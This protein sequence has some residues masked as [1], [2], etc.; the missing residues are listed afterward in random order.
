MTQDEENILQ[1]TEACSFR[2]GLKNPGFSYCHTENFLVGFFKRSAENF[3]HPCKHFHSAYEF[4]IPLSPITNL[5]A[6]NSVYL[7]EPNYIYP[8][9]SGRKHGIKYSQNNVSFISIIIEKVFF[10]NMM[11]E[12]GSS[13]MQF[14]TRLVYSDAL[15]DYI[16]NFRNEFA[17][18][19]VQD[20]LI[21]MPLRNLICA[22]LIRC[23]LTD[24]PDSRK[25]SSGYAPGISLVVKF[26]NDNYD[27]EINVEELAKI[28]G[29][30]KTYFSSMF[31]NIFGT[32]PK[33]YVNTLR[34]AKAK[35]LLE[36]SDTP[37]KIIATSCGFN[38][39]NTFFCAFRKS[40]NMTPSEFKRSR[41]DSAI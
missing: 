1:L 30:S 38:S 13:K 12:F 17:H 34:I 22:E 14:N 29:L 6:E 5:V 23:A 39:L 32:S 7:G 40:T 9:Q 19:A 20:K 33:A 37:I 4:I 16:K 8:V 3:V 28:C 24:S 15:H 21:L 11:N 18:S 2:R 10:E 27:K 31:K 35:N 25:E 26:I 41:K 36:F